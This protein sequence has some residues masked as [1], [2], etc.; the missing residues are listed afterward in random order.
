[1]TSSW[2]CK[3]C[4]FINPT[5]QNQKPTCE[6]CLTSFTSSS[7][8]S[9]P[10]SP[11]APK[12]SCKACTFLNLYKSTS[13]EVCGTRASVSSLSSFEDLN[14][15]DLDDV[16]LDSGVGSVFLPLQRCNK[17]KVQDLVVA[18][19]DCDELGGFRG[20]KASNKAVAVL[21]MWFFDPVVDGEDSVE[22]GGF[23]G[24]KEV[25]PDIYDI[26]C[27]SSWWKVYQCSVSNVMA[28]SRPYFCMLLSKLPVK[29]FSCKPFSNSAMG[30]E[31]CVAEVEIQKDKPLVVATSH[32]ESPC[33]GPP[34]WDQMYSKERVEQAKEAV[35]LLKK[36]P[37]VI[38]GGDMN[39]DDKL[40]GQFPFP[41]GWVDA[42]QELRPGNN[43]WTYDTK[44]NQMLTGNRTLQK[45]LDRF[46]CNLRD[47]KISGIEMIGMDAIPG[48]SYIKE[49]K[50]RK[51]VKKLELPV[52][53]SDHYGLL[54]TISSQ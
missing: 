21:E 20:I 24:V 44:S 53:P 25:T 36:D 45:R 51:E 23:R 35:N 41:D 47:Y 3:K 2:T 13:C 52:L 34:K 7:S 18:D 40:D 26:F 16:G 32:L 12:W 1:M 31:L 49:K 29:S 54:L 17:R 22:L 33:P 38:F 48:L 27:Q 14:D 37:N 15:T 5:S 4:T 10:P 19:E 9:S 8:S 50:V 28:N 6:I 39:W 30:R 43:G 11:S 42:W 46:I